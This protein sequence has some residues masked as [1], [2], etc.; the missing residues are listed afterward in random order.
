[1]ALHSAGDLLNFH[2]H[3][4]SLTLSGVVAEDGSFHPAG[5]VDTELLQEL[6]SNYLFAF[7]LKEELI[8]AELVESM[9][10][11]QHSG[12]HVFSG[13]PIQATESEKRLFVARYLKKCPISLKR[14]EILE[15]GLQ[16]TVRV[17]KEADDHEV[18]RDLSP[19][20]F[21]AEITQFIP[22]VSEQTTRY[23]GKYSAR[24]RGAA[25]RDEEFT[26]LVQNNFQ[27]LEQNE[28]KKP[29]SRTWRTWIKKVFEVDPLICPKCQTEM[30]IKA[31]IFNPKEIDRLCKNLGIEAARD[32]PPLK[33]ASWIE[34]VIEPI[35]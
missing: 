20:H 18:Y 25:R 17:Y 29:I 2:P 23:Y 30:K 1:M 13:E 32:P 34:P 4:H 28:E 7:L 14:L 27:P 35:E 11:W 15:N 26:A 21:L 10:E 3:V 33:N 19:L 8:S 16:A 6:F 12:F 5:A 24:T 22:A 31:F 9:R